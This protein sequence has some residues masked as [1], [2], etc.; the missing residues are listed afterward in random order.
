MYDY[1]MSSGLGIFDCVIP[2][3]NHLK[4]NDQNSG[5]VSIAQELSKLLKIECISN[6][7]VKTLNIRA[8]EILNN[9][10]HDF[11]QNNDLYIFSGIPKIKDKKILLVD[12]I[13]THDYTITQCI[14]QLGQEDPK[15][16]T[17]LCAGRT[18]K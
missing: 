3:T 12:D 9:Q 7:L 14:Y 8:R 5:A 16:I 10:K 2:V 11:W 17:V 4:N 13:I 6:A 18:E 15:D 1:L